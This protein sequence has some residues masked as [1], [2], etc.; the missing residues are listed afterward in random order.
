MQS[1]LTAWRLLMCLVVCVCVCV[2][3]QLW[4]LWLRPVQRQLRG[5][6]EGPLRVCQTGR[7]ACGPVV[8]RQV[9]A[10]V[11]DSQAVCVQ[12]LNHTQ[13]TFTTVTRI[14]E[15]ELSSCCRHRAHPPHP[16]PAPLRSCATSVLGGSVGN[17][18]QCASRQVFH[19]LSLPLLLLLLLL[20]RR[21]QVV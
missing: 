11:S 15:S 20:S 2:C 17:L 10:G 16:A 5:E 7:R 6:L 13:Q 19:N 4:R 21:V 14:R 3:V 8:S 9:W 12:L 18:I 1:L